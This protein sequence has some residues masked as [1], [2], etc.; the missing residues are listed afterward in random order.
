MAKLNLF[1]GKTVTNVIN[2]LK[3]NIQYVLLVLLIINIFYFPI[4]TNGKIDKLKENESRLENELLSI[5]SMMQKDRQALEKAADMRYEALQKVYSLN[6]EQT[7]TIS[8]IPEDNAFFKKWMIS[9]REETSKN[10]ENVTDK[11]E[12]MENAIGNLKASIDNIVISKDRNSISSVP[13]DNVESI[14]L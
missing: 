1:K 7:K 10:I 6:L 2:W 11:L 4:Y 5:K 14:S 13:K 3:I 12:N 9:N 8:Q